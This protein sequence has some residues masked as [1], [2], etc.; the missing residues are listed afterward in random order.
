MSKVFLAIVG[1]AFLI[2]GVVCFSQGSQALTGADKTAPAVHA[3]HDVYLHNCFQCHSVNEGEVRLGPSLYGEMKK[4]QPKK[5][6]TEIRT[7]LKNGKGKMPS[8]QEK[9]TEEDVDNLL[10]YIRTL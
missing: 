5:S 10:A 8:F 6:A 4:S 9:L 1:S 3:G 7:I 2:T